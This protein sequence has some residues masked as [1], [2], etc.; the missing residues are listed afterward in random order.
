VKLTIEV[1][2]EPSV[3]LLDSLRR[4]V[5]QLSSSAPE[6]GSAE[7]AELLDSGCTTLFIAR[8]DGR[9][10][11]TLTLASFRIPSGQRAWI[12]D[13]IVDESARGSGVGA[14]LTVAAIER[15][16]ELGVRSIDLTS[17]P[18]R[19]AANRLYQRLGFERRETN[20]YRYSLRG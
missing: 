20:V 6:L 3:E 11:G 18:G 17:R 2:T 10:C 12:E 4:L 5:P 13:V 7:L 16:R 1:A 14:A 9:I 15:A 19:E 8:L